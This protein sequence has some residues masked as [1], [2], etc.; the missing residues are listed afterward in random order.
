MVKIN[1]NLHFLTDLNKV[2]V[3]I[4]ATIKMDHVRSAKKFKSSKSNDKKSKVPCK[5]WLEGNCGKGNECSFSHDSQP[6]TQTT[7]ICKFFLTGSCLKGK[8][9]PYSHDTSLVP[10][11]FYHT[12]GFCTMGNACKYSHNPIDK[13]TQD[14]IRKEYGEYQKYERKTPKSLSNAVVSNITAGSGEAKMEEQ[15]EQ[16][17]ELKLKIYQLPPIFENVSKEEQNWIEEAIKKYKPYT[18]P[19]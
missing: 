15:S 9:C 13:E 19:F 6:K 2:D 10:C 11:K 14:K 12:K 3:Q 16:K 7:E 1:K 5:Y 18:S 17:P 4:H 8:K